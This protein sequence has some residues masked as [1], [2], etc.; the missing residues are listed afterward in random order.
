MADS[1]FLRPGESLRNLQA[2]EAIEE[3]P[4]ISQ[5]DLADRLGIA[6]GLT[7]ACLRNM[8]RK[9]LIKIKRVNSRNI[10]YHLTPAGISEK[11]RLS[12]AFAETTVE[13][14]R[15]AKREVSERMA[16]L[17][18]HGVT[19]IAIF[20]ATDLAEIVALVCGHSGIEVVGV[21]DDGEEHP[22]TYLG[23]EVGAPASLL[24]SGCEAVV[25]AYTVDVDRHHDRAKAL[26]G[27]RMPVI[28]AM[29]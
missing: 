16:A 11:A 7:N 29:G 28:R 2:L 22:E 12:I 13:F 19:K 18:E 8:A 20:G 15:T 4:N 14:Y 1:S 21:V 25:V 6:V 3:R 9:G 17:A 5:R 26:V 23:H 24:H 10:S 27:E